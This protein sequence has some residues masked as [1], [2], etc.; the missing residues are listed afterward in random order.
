MNTITEAILAA[1]PE[2]GA[3]YNK[4]TLAKLVEEFLERLASNARVESK[5]D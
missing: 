1:R 5:E 2:L 4:E 3:A